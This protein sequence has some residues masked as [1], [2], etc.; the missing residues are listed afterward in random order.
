MGEIVEPSFTFE[1]V[2]FRVPTRHICRP[3]KQKM[4]GK[5]L[6]L[7]SAHQVWAFTKEYS[8]TGEYETLFICQAHEERS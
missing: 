3:F 1:W 6:F 7:D 8:K 4:P 5:M 2:D